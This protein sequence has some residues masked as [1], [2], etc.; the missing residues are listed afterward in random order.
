MALSAGSPALAHF[1]AA[2]ARVNRRGPTK[3]RFG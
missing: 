1:E 3:M 2:D